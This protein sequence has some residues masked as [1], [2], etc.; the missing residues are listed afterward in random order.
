MIT[1]VQLRKTADEFN[2]VMLLKPPIDINLDLNTLVEVITLVVTEVDDEGLPFIREGDTYEPETMDV[3]DAINHLEKGEVLY[4]EP[5]GDKP[6]VSE[7]FR[8]VQT[9]MKLREL[10]DV[11]IANIE[12]KS[13]RGELSSY[14]NVEELREKMFE[15]LTQTK[16]EEKELLAESAEVGL[17]VN[18][19]F[20]KACPKLSEEE[21]SALE[22]LLLKDG[23][24]INPILTWHNYIVD[25]HNRFEL[26][27]AHNLPY[28]TEEREFASEDDVVV[29]IKENAIS[30]RNLTAFARYELIKD[31]EG[32]LK[33]EGKKRMKE[34]GT[35][36][37]KHRTEEEKQ[38]PK[39]DTRKTMAKTA[40]M[41]PSQLAKAKVVEEE[42]PEE[43]KAKVRTGE[44]KL[45]KAFDEVVKKP[46]EKV[47]K[48]K[49]INK[50]VFLLNRW[51]NKYTKHEL[52]KDIAD[53]RDQLK[54]I[55]TPKN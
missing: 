23:R 21:Y 37:G 39:H 3:I 1:E 17:Q 33:A 25:G 53:A 16:L 22:T 26:A 41:S 54:E 34:K 30:Q 48:F 14:N 36:P 46:K 32:I 9:T 7:L 49:D 4:V 29:W 5:S 24:V 50:A 42:A 19:R 27:T 52:A 12:F 2:K 11:A 28:Q 40:K 38:Q 35:A 20:A 10:K 45:S 43:L 31:I 8:E 13:I 51:L 44:I 55:L 47:D 15:L 18:P 6:E